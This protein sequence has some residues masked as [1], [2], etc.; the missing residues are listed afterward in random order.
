M[1]RDLFLWLLTAFVVEPV[2]AEWGARLAAMR[3]PPALIAELRQCAAQAGPALAGRA[4]GDPW[5]GV[6]TAVGVWIGATDGGAVIAAATP[7]C[8]AVVTAARPLL[9]GSRS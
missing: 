6:T 7:G 4:V 2:Q 8:A 9:D 5:W 3:A 1:I